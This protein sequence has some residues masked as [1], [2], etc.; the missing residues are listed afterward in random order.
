M[1]G[2]TV[3]EQV[4]IKLSIPNESG[5]TLNARLVQ[6]LAVYLVDTVQIQDVDELIIS[7][8]PAIAEEA[9]QHAFKQ[10]LPGVHARAL[11][12]Y[13]GR[14]DVPKGFRPSAPPSVVFAADE[15]SDE[16]DEASTLFGAAGPTTR[17][18]AKLAEDKKAHGFS[19]MRI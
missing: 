16:E 5:K 19:G 17:D 3:K 6:A 1:S 2:A 12:A 18:L 14:T 8:L 9:W 13:V 4:V 10:S 11:I 7:D 15:D